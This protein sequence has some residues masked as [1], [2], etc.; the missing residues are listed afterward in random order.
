MAAI[1]AADEIERPEG[2]AAQISLGMRLARFALF[3]PT[4]GFHK[5]KQLGSASLPAAMII[6]FLVVATYV[7]SA[8]IPALSLTPPI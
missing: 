7:T 2:L 4:E 6:L 5:I 1:A 3:H 8:S